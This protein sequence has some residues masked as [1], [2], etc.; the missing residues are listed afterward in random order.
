V[1]ANVVKVVLA[2]VKLQVKHVLVKLKTA[3]LLVV[4]TASQNVVNQPQLIQLLIN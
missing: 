1:I 4:K 3:N 2:N